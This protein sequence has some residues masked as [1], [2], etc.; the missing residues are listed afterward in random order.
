MQQQQQN[1]FC[2]Y[3]Y[4]KMMYHTCIYVMILRQMK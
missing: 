2:Q 3:P 1:N 4:R